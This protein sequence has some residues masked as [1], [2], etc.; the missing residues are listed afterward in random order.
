MK[1]IT[2]VVFMIFCGFI[3]DTCTKDGNKP[4]DY[5]DKYTGKYK[6]SLIIS[7]YGPCDT[8]YTKKDTSIT[9]KYGLTDSTLNVLGREVRLDSTGEYYTYH[10]VLRLWNDSISSFYMNGGLGCG[11]HEIYQGVRISN[12]P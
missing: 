12:T 7:C 9:V 3:F 5:R 8:C 6:G 1:K 10:Y 4:T 11:Q 2:L